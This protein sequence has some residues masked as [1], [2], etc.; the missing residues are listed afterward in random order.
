[1]YLYKDC[2]SPYYQIIYYT[3]GKRT[4]KSTK[5]KIKS[6]ALKFLSEF[7]EHLKKE[8]EVKPITLSQFQKEYVDYLSIKSKSYQRSAT[9]SFNQLKK[10]IG[11]NILLQEINYKLLETFLLSVYSKSEFGAALYYRTLKAAFNKAVNWDYIPE[12]LLKRIKLPKPKS[13]FPVFIDTNEFQLILAQVKEDYLRVLY[14]TALNTGMRRSELINLKWGVVDFQNRIIT[15]KN[16]SDFTTKSGKERIIPMNTILLAMLSEYKPKIVGID[17][18]KNRYLFT[19]IENI[20]LAEDFVS[21]KFKK[22]LRAAKLDDRIHMHTLRHSFAS[23]LVQRG[24]SLLAVK[25]LLGHSDLRTTQIYTHLQHSD[26]EQAVNVLS[27]NGVA[28]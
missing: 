12:N 26:L 9:T 25:E 21:K 28:V 13:S 8:K 16:T 11:R 15:V 20:K 17:G 18:S 6:Q 10:Y 27:M 3:N 1:M 24:V 5:K 14:A 7:N 2:Y 19:R 4:R 23:L 22:A